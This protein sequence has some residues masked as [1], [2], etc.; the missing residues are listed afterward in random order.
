MPFIFTEDYG[1]T[2]IYSTLSPLLKWPVNTPE[3][4][5]KEVFVCIADYGHSTG[6]NLATEKSYFFTVLVNNLQRILD[7]IIINAGDQIYSIVILRELQIIPNSVNLDMDVVYT[8][9]C[10]QVR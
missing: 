3:N 1:Q 8:H 4:R 9:N 7:R 6:F 5:N 10:H 2:W